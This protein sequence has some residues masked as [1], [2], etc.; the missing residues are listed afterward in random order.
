MQAT[1]VTCCLPST[2]DGTVQNPA[3]LLPLC[4][5]ATDRLAPPPLLRLPRSTPRACLQSRGHGRAQDRLLRGEPAVAE[6]VAA[7]AGFLCAVTLG[8]LAARRT[9]C[10]EASLTV[11]EPQQQV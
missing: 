7:R 9:C 10:C 2:R 8:P 1:L 4:M 5:C 6:A 11:Q 3:I